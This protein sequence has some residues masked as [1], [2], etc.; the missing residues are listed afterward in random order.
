MN[1]DM[2]TIKDVALVAGVSHM[3]V[4]RALNNSPMIAP[5]TRELVLK[6]A[7]ELN[8]KPNYNAK[9]LVTS[10]SY[11]IGVF[12]ST[13]KTNTAPSFFQSCLWGIYESLPRDYQLIIKD[14]SDGIEHI[15][16]SRVDGVILVSQQSS[17]DQFIEMVQKHKVPLVVLNRF[18]ESVDMANIVV[19]EV[20]GA[21]EA[22]RYLIKQGHK[23]IAI[24]NGPQNI[25]SSHDRMLG[26]QL[27]L[28]E[29]KIEIGEHNF[30]YGEFSIQGG[31]LAM[32]SILG[33]A[34]RPSAVFCANDEMAVGA[35]KAIHES[36]LQV[37]QD[38]A[39]IGFNDS[40]ISQYTTPALTTIRKPIQQ[41][42]QIGCNV[43]FELIAGNQL[44]T[45]HQKLATELVIRASA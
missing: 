21:A 15:N 44:A 36:D 41:M 10:K 16:L 11:T 45:S 2:A 19:D 25:Q 40:E 6:V 12:F 7:A 18:I 3:T 32:Q 23:Q 35:L 27:A 43:L 20:S 4:S 14:L 22:V 34:L 33:Q 29:S 17:D 8:Y 9:S 5:A 26:Y 30:G 13:I 42:A 28:A 31:Y 24:L 39:L 37:P 38:I 1:E